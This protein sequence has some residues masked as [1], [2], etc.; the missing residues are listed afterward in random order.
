MKKMIAILMLALAPGIQS[1]GQ[2][3]GGLD[4]LMKAQAA[5]FGEFRKSI[6]QDYQGF[7]DSIDREYSAYLRKVW[8]SRNLA[9]GQK[10]DSTP[11]PKALPRFNPAV[12][13]V[14]PGTVPMLVVPLSGE[15]PLP[16]IPVTV[17]VPAP[18]EYEEEA[19][20]PV[21]VPAPAPGKNGLDFYGRR[22]F[23]DLSPELNGQLPR[24][25]HNTT[26]A[27]FWDRMNKINPA[28][29]LRQLNESKAELNLN[30][31]GFYLLV[32][33]SAES[34]NP[35]TSYS[36]LLTWYLMAKSGYRVRVAYNDN[37][38]VLM[39]P[40]T[41]AIYDI[42]WFMSGEVKYYAP[43]CPMNTVYTYDKDVPG[44][45]RVFDMN[46]LSPPSLGEQPATREVMFS[47]GGK[48][49]SFAFKYNKAA[50]SFYN[51]YPLCDLKVYFDAAVSPGSREAMMN[52]LKPA[53]EKL[54]PRESVDFLLRLVQLGFQYKTDP[55]QF[56]R[57]K[58]DFPEEI[59]HYPYAD[60]DDRS[61]F[62][63][64]LVR[65]L[66]GMKVI[67]VVYPGHVATAVNFPDDEEGDF[68]LFHGDKYV[69]A[70]PT[71]ISAPVGLT[72]PGK[73]NATATVIELLNRQG[74]ALAVS[75]V[76]ERAMSGGGYQGDNRMNAVTDRDGNTY[77]TG[78]YKSQATLGETMLT[79]AD[80]SDNVFIA[81][82]DRSGNVVWAKK[83]TDGAAGR[84]YNINMDDKGDLYISGTFGKMMALGTFNIIFSKG[85][86]GLF[87]LKMKQDGEAVWLRQADFSKVKEDESQVLLS[88]FTASGEQVRSEI[89]PYDPAFTNFGISFD[90]TGNVFFSA[91]WSATL[92]L[93]VDRIALGLEASFDPVI[94]LKDENDKQVSD[95]CDPAIAG[96]FAVINVMRLNDV[97][98]SGKIVQLALQRFNPGFM[99][100]HPGLYESIG[101]LKVMKNSSGIVTILTE[102]MKPVTIDKLKI[103]N[104]SRLRI[105]GLPGGDAKVD[106]LSGVKVGK[107]IVWYDLNYVRL[108]R[109]NGNITFDYSSNHSQVTLNMRKDLLN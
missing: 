27:D 11:K 88:E 52:L 61:V 55:E 77:I 21:P 36:R 83:G 24:E 108:Y 107:A 60:C 41:S 33:R 62:F 39:F 65:E 86:G 32:K 48:E 16:M 106:V 91:P 109:A 59:L 94:T 31:W 40:A 64:W 49:Y 22:V 44:A 47:Y 70:D 98:L 99:R 75:S 26:V 2:T 85:E 4:S 105:S 82:F 96:L 17:P 78:Y 95:K 20:S 63:A 68:I 102:E 13:R 58:F 35:D 18:Y 92:G 69:I 45:T 28:G 89:Y 37:R 38:I 3:G 84:G 19:P 54:S 14:K 12:D 103:T 30:D 23:L 97:S 50:I 76:W 5:Q 1:P 71:Y 100:S 9:A 10:S 42:R 15:R 81:K 46:I 53:I 57:E 56:G 66:T 67:G 74:E 7:R 80:S 79:S 72:M 34:V 8:A 90:R 25:I 73:A 93:K 29:L 104:G 6:G 43:D 51:D 101:R 87:L